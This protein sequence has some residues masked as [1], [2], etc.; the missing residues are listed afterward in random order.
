M[1][2]RAHCVCAAL[3]NSIDVAP[4]IYKIQDLCYVKL[5][6]NKRAFKTKFNCRKFTN[7][8]FFVKNE[9]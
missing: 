1:L 6:Y 4:L 3:V 5:D 9:K 2:L 8:D 7:E